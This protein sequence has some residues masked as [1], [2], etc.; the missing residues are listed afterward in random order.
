MTRSGTLAAVERR[1]E[2]RLKADLLQEGLIVFLNLILI[3][4]N[5]CLYGNEWFLGIRPEAEGSTEL[6]P[7]FVR[8]IIV[9][10]Y[11]WDVIECIELQLL[12]NF[13]IIPFNG[14]DDFGDVSSMG[15]ELSMYVAAF[16][17]SSPVV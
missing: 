6:Q 13:F 5:Q 3:V 1:F 9:P 15:V 14:L 8:Y 12:K 7:R 4:C 17:S 11:L 2:L 16:I 10:L